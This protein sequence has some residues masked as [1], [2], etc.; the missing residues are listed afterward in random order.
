MTQEVLMNFTN[1]ICSFTGYRPKKLYESLGENGL[2]ALKERLRAE[3]D[4]LL[5]DDFSTFQCGMALGSDMLFAD[6]VLEY[7]RK[8]PRVKL[9][10]VV[11]C[12]GQ[13]NSWNE[14]QKLKY[15]QLLEGASEVKIISNREYFD[16][17]MQIRNREL[18]DS[19]DLLLAVY[20]GK[21]GGTMQTVELAKKQGK[22]IRIIDPSTLLRVTLYQQG[23]F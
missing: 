18:A 5:C 14:K 8:Y 3:V 16:G 23:R 22:K 2:P 1:K 10:A 21:R 4:E 13:E 12:I 11:P 6:V 7:K 17:C 15:Q 20:D 19:C 9:I